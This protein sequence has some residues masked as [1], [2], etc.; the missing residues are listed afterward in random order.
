MNQDYFATPAGQAYIQRM[1]AK[2]VGDP[3]ELVGTVLLLASSAGSFINGAVLTVDGGLT[4]G[5]P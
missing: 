4:A 2:R 5:A 3:D 1:P